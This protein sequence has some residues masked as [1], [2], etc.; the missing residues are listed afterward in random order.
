MLDRLDDTIVAVSSA[1]GYG[2]LG[3]VRLCGPQAI[4]IAAKATSLVNGRSL[5]HLPG[6]RRAVGEVFLDARLG[7]PAALLVFRAP[8]S[9]TRQDMVEIH[10][11]GSRAVLDAVCR[12][13]IEL[14]AFQALPGEFT[15]RAFVYGAMDLASAE[16]VSGLIRAQT[17]TQL[18]ASRRMMEGATANRIKQV[19]DELAE[20]LALV[21]ADI[22]F[23][24]EPIEFITP[25]ALRERLEALR[26]QLNKLSESSMRV[27]HFNVLPHILLLG[28]PNAGKSSLM[29]RLSGTS[30][31]ICAAA[32]GTT[33]DILSAPIRLDR[34]EAILLD[35]AGLDHTECEI[36]QQAR[37]NA[38]AIAERVDV[39]C[40][41]FDLTVAPDQGVLERAVSLDTARIVIAANKCDRVSTDESLKAAARLRDEELGPVCTISALTG[42]GIDTLRAT[43]TDA[44]ASSTT[45]TLGE[46]ALISERQAAAIHEGTEAIARAST[47]ASSAIETIDCAETIAFELREALDLL[48]TV[49]GNVTTEDLLGKVFANFCIGK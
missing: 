2:R 24:E 38:L 26:S 15:A 30:R 17:D 43:L 22:D 16:A 11:V 6:S 3:I 1:P 33:R 46:S 32:A 13:L 8:H 18:R 48:A 27:E 12:R 14:G 47:L 42:A 19:R 40:L 29:N 4:Q 36:M 20:I 9:Y 44:V 49:S 45:T 35:T 23:A 5:D 10:T 21:E 28:P 39:V 37:A 7:V 34:G 25:A 31:A 41:V